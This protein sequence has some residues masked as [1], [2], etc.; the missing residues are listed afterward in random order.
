MD[1]GLEMF[2]FMGLILKLPILGACWLI[3]HAVRAEPELIEGA[4]DE[5]GHEHRRFRRDPRPKR[6]AGPRRGPHAPDALP[7]PCP[8]EE[9]GLQ[10]MRRPAKPGLATGSARERR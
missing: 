9:G 4:E 5:G 3:W 7:L 8:A 1:L 10:V 6:P 2:I